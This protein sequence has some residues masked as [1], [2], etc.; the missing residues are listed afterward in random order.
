MN[1]DKRA[2][3]AG[4][5]SRDA[6]E[7][8]LV[9][10]EAVMS[11]FK[12]EANEERLQAIRHVLMQAVDHIEAQHGPESAAMWLDEANEAIQQRIAELSPRGGSPPIQNADVGF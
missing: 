4:H 1:A 6:K 5:L 11:E 12:G 2:P 7:F 10:A 3:D 9:V 8:G